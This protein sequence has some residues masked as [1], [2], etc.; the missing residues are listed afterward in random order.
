MYLVS[1]WPLFMHYTDKQAAST[2]VFHLLMTKVSKGYRLHY[3]L[4]VSKS[5]GDPSA[6]NKPIFVKA[7][8]LAD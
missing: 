8:Y 3:L 7:L 1:L 2:Y 6:T 4:P 5:F